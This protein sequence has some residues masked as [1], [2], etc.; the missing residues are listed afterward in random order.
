MV[1]QAQN[2]EGET[3]A[4]TKMTEQYTLTASQGYLVTGRSEGD[5]KEL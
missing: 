5:H 2:V 4:L 1:A 3:N